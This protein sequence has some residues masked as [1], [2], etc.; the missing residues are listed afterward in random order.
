MAIYMSSDA[1]TDGEEV[2]VRSSSKFEDSMKGVCFMHVLNK[3]SKVIPFKEKS[4]RK[5]RECALEWI[6]LKGSYESK[7]AVKALTLD[8]HS[9][10][11]TWTATVG[12]GLAADAIAIT[13]YE[14]EG[15]GRKQQYYAGYHARCY[16]HFCNITT[17]KRAITKRRKKKEAEKIQEEG[18]DAL[19][20]DEP[21]DQMPKRLLQS[22][23]SDG[24]RTSAHQHTDQRHVLPV[25]CIIC[26]GRQYFKEQCSGKRRVEKLVQCD[27][28]HGG[29]LLT[30][31][32][33][34]RDEAILLHIRDQDI[35]AIEARYHTSCYHRYIRIIAQALQVS[36]QECPQQL[37]EKSYISFCKKFIE[38][39]IIRGKEFVRLSKLNQLFIEEVHE[40]EN[41][42]ASSY[43]AGQLKARLRRSYPCLCFARSS[44]QKEGDIVF[45]EFLAD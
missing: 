43:K 1:T 42:D 17:I 5:F 20:N 21:L 30:A 11:H 19:P 28:K 27:A 7:F 23:T 2:D 36:K 14:G 34:K 33:L 12:V 45:V 8:Q 9:L 4:A 40:I 6:Q 44:R 37:Y 26:K 24:Q 35:V 38:E 39:R 18:S 3:Q 16:N 25:Q 31:A 13:D 29:Q 15:S 32:T 41:A 10:L 22:Y